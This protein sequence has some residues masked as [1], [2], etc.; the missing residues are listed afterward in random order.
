MRRWLL[1]LLLLPALA[2]AQGMDIWI[3]DLADELRPVQRVTDREGYDN[4]PSFTSDGKS[5]LFSSDRA[6]GQVDLFRFELA[7]GKIANLTDTADENEFSAQDWRGEQLMYVLQEGVPYQH[8]WRRSWNGGERERALTS[9][10]PVGYYARNDVGVLFWGRY[11]YAL[12]FEPADAEVG[13]GAGETLRVIDQ[14]GR[15]IHAIPGSNDFSFV[16]KQADWRWIIKRLDP[17]TGA[18]TPIIPISN[19]NEDYCWTPDGALLIAD[20]RSLLRYRPGDEGTWQTVGGLEA[21]GFGSGGRCAVSPDGR[22]L[23]VVS[24][25]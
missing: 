23:A 24:P 22:R 25:R 14:A 16:H 1:L 2:G 18:V 12:F 7:S 19:E 11:T 8:L 10:V 17:A 3:F 21:D 9:Y 20:G 6:G 15:S 13:P 5:L 4:Q